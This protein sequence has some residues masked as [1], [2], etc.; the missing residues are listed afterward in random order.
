MDALT[1]IYGKEVKNKNNVRFMKIE[2][3]L[4]DF[5][6]GKS[7]FRVRDVVNSGNII[8]EAINQFLNNNSDE[9]IREM[10]PA[11]AKAISQHFKAFLNSAFLQIPLK[12]WLPD[13]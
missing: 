10:K 9:I 2:R 3:M 13:A 12:I 8:G 1:R 5:K 11:A 4:S 7:R 6:L